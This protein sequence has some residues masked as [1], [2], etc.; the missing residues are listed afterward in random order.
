MISM[1]LP[2]G[3]SSWIYNSSEE[4]ETTLDYGNEKVNVNVYDVTQSNVE[5]IYYKT[6]SMPEGVEY[7]AT[8]DL[9]DLKHDL[10]SITDDFVTFAFG[11]QALVIISTGVRY[12]IPEV[13]A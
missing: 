10:E 1:L 13:I 11:E 9:N 6:G 3:F 2:V 12:V 8:V 4:T 7:V 5:K